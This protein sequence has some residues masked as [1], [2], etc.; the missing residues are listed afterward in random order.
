MILRQEN[1]LKHGKSFALNPE[2]KEVGYYQDY[3]KDVII[4][5]V[6]K[7]AKSPP[8][9]PKKLFDQSFTRCNRR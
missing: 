5:Q 6:D 3:V 9:G 7:N 8:L 2:T 1:I 4:Q